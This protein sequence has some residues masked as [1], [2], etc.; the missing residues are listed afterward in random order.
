MQV[1]PMRVGDRVHVLRGVLAMVS[2]GIDATAS[3]I[4]MEVEPIVLER[5][6]PVSAD[7]STQLYTLVLDGDHTYFANQLLV[8]NK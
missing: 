6:E 5:I 4:E 3:P 1:E 2:T 8:H 7:R